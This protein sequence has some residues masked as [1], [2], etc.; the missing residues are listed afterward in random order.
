MS[1]ALMLNPQLKLAATEENLKSVKVI[2]FETKSGDTKGDTKFVIGPSGTGPKARMI[3]IEQQE[4]NELIKGKTRAEILH[5]LEEKTGRKF[6]L[7]KENL[8]SAD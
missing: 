8:Y 7:K 2:A 4:V 6:K 3:I 1:F 5:L